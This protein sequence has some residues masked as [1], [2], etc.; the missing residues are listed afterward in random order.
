MPDPATGRKRGRRTTWRL[1]GSDRARGG[2][3]RDR[4][5][6]ALAL[7]MIEDL[8]DDG[9]VFDA[10]DNAHGSATVGTGL[11]TEKYAHLAPDNVRTAV[12]VLDGSV[13]HFCHSEELPGVA[14]AV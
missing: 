13:S 11:D 1:S 10:G 8:C 12:A 4:R 2:R 5:L 6:S 3:Q 14:D 7:E 9:G